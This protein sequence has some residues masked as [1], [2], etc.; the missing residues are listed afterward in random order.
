MGDGRRAK[1]S[2]CAYLAILVG[3][4]V[5]SAKAK[6]VF[7]VDG[8]EVKVW[9][10]RDDLE[11]ESEGESCTADHEAEDSE[12][13]DEGEDSDE[14]GCSSSSSEEESETS[15]DEDGEDTIDGPSSC[16]ESHSSPVPSSPP[17]RSH[18]DRVAIPQPSPS[19]A[20]EQQ[21]L[22]LAE[23]LLSRTLATAD[24]EGHSMAAEM[25]TSRSASPHHFCTYWLTG[26]TSS[27]T[28]ARPASRAPAVRA[29]CVDTAT[30]HV[31]LA[32][33]GVAGVPGGLWDTG[34]R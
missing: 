32:R 34:R 6:V 19:Y 15:S 23:R 7:A 24:G 1:R 22:R 14:C 30:E 3:P 20:E 33:W 13:D 28:D 29:S 4:S 31:R 11:A 12:D 17:S 26:C 25:G 9:G 2:A 16:E 27:D 5:G 8:L 18:H 21:A 10:Q